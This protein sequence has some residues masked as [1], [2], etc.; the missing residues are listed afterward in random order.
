MKDM[1]IAIKEFYSWETETTKDRVIEVI[2]K[3]WIT[4]LGLIAVIGWLTVVGATIMN[5]SMWDNVQF[6]IYDTLGY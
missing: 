1:L 3:F 5:P 4:G 2:A 6:G